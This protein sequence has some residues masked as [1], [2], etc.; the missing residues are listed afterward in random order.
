MEVRFI[1]NKM[2]YRGLAFL[3]TVGMV[4]SAGY[5][6]FPVTKISKE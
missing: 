3:T 6:D 2:I 1:I 4:S 5:M